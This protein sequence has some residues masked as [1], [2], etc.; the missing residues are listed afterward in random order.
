MRGKSLPSLRQDDFHAHGHLV[1][2]IF[3]VGVRHDHSMIL[4]SHVALGDELINL[5]K[6]SH[7]RQNLDPLSIC[8]PPVVNVPP[9]RIATHKADGADVR[10]VANEVHAVVLVKLR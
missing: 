3:L 9:C 1:D 10:M 5:K 2:T 4:R 8:R 7:S 6:V